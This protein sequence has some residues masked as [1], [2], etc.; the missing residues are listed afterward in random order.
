MAFS[1]L[2]KFL[3]NNITS[4]V[5]GIIGSLIAVLLQVFVMVTVNTLTYFFTSRMRLKR[6]FSIKASPGEIIVV[7]GSVEGLT[8]P[9]VAFLAGPD[10][11]AAMNILRSL[12]NIYPA[13]SI[14]HIYA[15]IDNSVP[16]FSDDIVTVG[17][18]VFNPIA[19]YMLEHS[20]FDVRFDERD[21]LVCDGN[22]YDNSM[23]ASVDYGLVYRFKNPLANDK[24]T[25]VIAGCGSHGVLAAS[26]LFETNNRFKEL[27]KSFAKKR[28]FVNNI[29]NKDFLVIVKCRIWGNDISNLN[30]ETIKTIGVHHD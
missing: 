30:I 28:G 19:K 17:G 7:S 10:A 18:P 6:L 14:K 25:T 8:N 29:L 23:D 3:N 15:T 9:G 22:I 5:T 2:L 24:K 16:A 13:S 4:I 1:D 11:S 20:P 21:M 27:R 12:Q 26:M